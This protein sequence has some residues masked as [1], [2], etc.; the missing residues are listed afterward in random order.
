MAARLFYVHNV[1]NISLVLPSVYFQ[2]A[3]QP[4]EQDF[5]IKGREILQVISYRHLVLCVGRNVT[6]YIILY[7]LCIFV[8]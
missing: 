5:G 7:S 8:F 6:N 3:N 4:F 1:T 2:P